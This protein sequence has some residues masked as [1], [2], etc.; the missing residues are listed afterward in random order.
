MKVLVPVKRVVD[1]YV[2]VRV[3]TDGTDVDTKN[4]KMA[5]NP[6]DEIAVEEAIRWKEAG[7]V[8]ETTGVS[9]GPIAVQETLRQA[10]ALGLD[11]AIHV[12][13]DQNLEPLAI[14]KVLKAIVTRQQTGIVI[15][16]KQA[17]DDDCNQTGQ[18]LAA[19]LEWP[20][21]TFAS[22]VEFAQ[23]QQSITVSREV[24]DGL[25]ILTLPLPAV[26]TTDLRLNTPRY[27][28][29]PNIMQAKRKPIESVSLVELGV[30]TAPRITRLKV[31]PPHSRPPGKQV[32]DVASLIQCLKNEAKVL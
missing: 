17:I 25:E 12:Q 14:A 27:A 18:M 30:D 16:G 20:Q 31:A 10:L 5:M 1:P 26:I 2:K 8:S 15:M 29:L 13:C 7:L 21:A 23:E 6:F 28:T 9:I 19:L 11:N 24:D 4:V 3:R 22:K 32:D